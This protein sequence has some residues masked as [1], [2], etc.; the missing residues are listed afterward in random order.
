[1]GVPENALKWS[2]RAYLALFMG[3]LLFPLLY[4]MLLAFNDSRIPTHRDFRFTVKWFGAAWDD[5]RMWQGLETSFIIGIMVVAISIPLGLAG[6]ILL[7]RLQ[8]RARSLVYAILVSPI[9]APGIVL[10]I[11]TFIFWSQQLGFRA[12]WWTAALAQCSFIAAYCM[13]IFMARLQRLDVSLEEAALD[14]GAKPRHIFWRITVP[15][16]RPAFLSAAALAFLQ[17]FENYT[18]TYFSIGAEQTF[19]IFIANKVRQ[20]VTP[21][22]NAVAFVIIVLTIALSIVANMRRARQRR[23]AVEPAERAKP[24][25]LAAAEGLPPIS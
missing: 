24:A 2:V 5:Q 17:S 15:Y 7:V 16:M 25:P 4:M 14:L 20:G 19:T 10:G 12:G 9:L 21:A 22:V 18:T 1:M 8:I 13:L 3:Y 23:A 6:A 11:S